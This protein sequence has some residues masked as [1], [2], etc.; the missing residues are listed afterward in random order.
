MKKLIAIIAML[1][2]GLATFAQENTTAASNDEIKAVF[3]QG[4]KMKIGWF[5]EGSGGYTK[6]CSTD[7]GLAGISGGIIINH[8]FSIGLTASGVANS[9]Q[10]TYKNFIE[11]KDARLEAGWGGL[12]IEYTLF[13]KSPVHVTFPLMIGGGQVS[14]ISTDESYD[15]VSNKWECSHEVLA[16]DGIFV[17]EPGVKAEVNIFRFMRLGAGISYRYTPDLDLPNT[18]TDFINNFTVGGSIKFGKF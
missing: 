3:G 15:P 13:P 6:F 16:S 12:R 2:L 5:I 7:I 10:I 11:G 14:Y 1:G 9:Q 4:N 18:S 8:N 17:V